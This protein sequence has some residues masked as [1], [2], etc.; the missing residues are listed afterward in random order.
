MNSIISIIG[1]RDLVSKNQQRLDILFY[2]S[3]K[4]VKTGI[5]QPLQTTQ[6]EKYENRGHNLNGVHR[7]PSVHHDRTITWNKKESIIIHKQK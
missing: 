3:T 7:Q 6:K 2:F 1:Y 4:H 5:Q